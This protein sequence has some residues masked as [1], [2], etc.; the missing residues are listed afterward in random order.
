[1]R[2]YTS[3]SRSSRVTSGPSSRSTLRC[4]LALAGVRFLLRTRCLNAC[5]AHC[6]SFYAQANEELL[7]SVNSQHLPLKQR[8]TSDRC[9]GLGQTSESGNNGEDERLIRASEGCGAALQ[10]VELR[11]LSSY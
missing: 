8:L 3:L 10:H 5:Q 7:A 6:V 2:P 1:M 4:S 11:G 9:A